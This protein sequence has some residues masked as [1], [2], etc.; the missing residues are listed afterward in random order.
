[1]RTLYD[2]LLTC[3]PLLLMLGFIPLVENDYYLAGIY[4]AFGLVYFYN[5]NTKETIIVYTTGLI[6]MTIFESIF[7]KTGVE[8]FIRNSFLGIMPLWLPL[9]WAYG[10]LVIK[11]SL[12][13]LK[14]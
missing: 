1:M 12:K 2:L 9:L 6:A 14:I 5:H 10:F 8:V 13:A 11:D 4:L 7:L 3:T